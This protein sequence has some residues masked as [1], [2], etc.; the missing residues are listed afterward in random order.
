MVRKTSTNGLVETHQPDNASGIVK[1]TQQFE[2]DEPLFRQLVGG[3]PPKVARVAGRVLARL[4]AGAR[5]WELGGKRLLAGAREVVSIPI[6]QRYRLLCDASGQ[7]LR[8]V[9]VLTHADYNAPH[10]RRLH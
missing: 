9:V 8:P 10:K 5:Y 6:G 1:H 3:L 7:R 4:A 2:M